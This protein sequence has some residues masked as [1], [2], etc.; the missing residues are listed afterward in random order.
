[1]LHGDQWSRAV[2]PHEAAKVLAAP[3][4][5]KTDFTGR[6]FEVAVQ[7]EWKRRRNDRKRARKI[8]RGP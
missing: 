5:L 3:R 7:P 8:L 2:T 1:M 4:P 6:G